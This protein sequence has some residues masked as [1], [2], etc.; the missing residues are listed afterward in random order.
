VNYEEPEDD[1]S[2]DLRRLQRNAG[3]GQTLPQTNRV[4]VSHPGFLIFV[5]P[6]YVVESQDGAGDERA[7]KEYRLQIELIVGNG[8][9]IDQPQERAQCGDDL[10]GEYN[11][12]RQIGKANMVME[13]FVV[14]H[15][16]TF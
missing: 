16:P 8:W 10:A 7:A 15:R 6:E 14:G 9:P 2:R 1:A 3:S 5:W 4:T 12:G 13:Y 11:R